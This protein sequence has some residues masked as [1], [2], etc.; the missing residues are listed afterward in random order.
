MVS[1]KGELLKM[2]MSENTIKV[3]SKAAKE[4]SYPLFVKADIDGFFFFF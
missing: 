1:L 4:V 2:A 3:T